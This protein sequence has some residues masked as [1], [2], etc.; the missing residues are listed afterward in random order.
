MDID[1]A[2]LEEVR[3]YTEAKGLLDVEFRM[4]D[5]RTTEVTEKFDLVYAHFPTYESDWRS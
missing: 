1:D 4:S 2:R 5:I 3:E